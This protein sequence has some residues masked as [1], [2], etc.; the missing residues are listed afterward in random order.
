M[1][2]PRRPAGQDGPPAGTS[3]TLTP[4]LPFRLI[5]CLSVQLQSRERCSSGRTGEAGT[6][7]PHRLIQLSSSRLPTRH[8]PLAASRLRAVEASCPSCRILLPVLR[9]AAPAPPYPAPS[10]PG[11]SVLLEAGSFR[12][13]EVRAR[14]MGG[15]SE[16]GRSHTAERGLS[17]RDAAGASARSRF[18]PRRTQV[19]LQDLLPALPSS[20]FQADHGTV[21]CTSPLTEDQKLVWRQLPRL[22]PLPLY[23]VGIW[24]REF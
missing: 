17:S 11:V 10:V 2:L 14:A 15:R 18:L 23:S 1:R 24:I 12:L 3:G 19:A 8:L 22:A 21:V 6:L 13:R 9:A 7:L 16:A 4:P 20:F 5:V